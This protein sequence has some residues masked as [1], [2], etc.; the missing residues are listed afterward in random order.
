L[1][2][3]PLATIFSSGSPLLFNASR[4]SSVNEIDR[5]TFTSMEDSHSELIANEVLA[6]PLVWLHYS[7]GLGI[8]QPFLGMVLNMFCNIQSHMN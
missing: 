2:L 7:L 3:F 5:C 6:L 1:E 8:R 4:S